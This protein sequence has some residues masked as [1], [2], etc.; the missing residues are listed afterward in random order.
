MML[1][2]IVRVQRVKSVTAPGRA[3][4][5]DDLCSYGTNSLLITYSTAYLVN[6]A[7]TNTCNC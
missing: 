6:N 4:V 7:N 1:E 5:A 3:G 2:C